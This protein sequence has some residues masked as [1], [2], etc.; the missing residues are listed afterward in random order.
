MNS[1]SY[2]FGL[3]FQISDDYLDVEKDK[4]DKVFLN[5][6]LNLG[7]KRTLEIYDFHFKKCINLLKNNLYS[8]HF[9]EILILL[10][11]RIYEQKSI[12]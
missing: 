6:F 8:K 11:K 10:N 7:K 2:S 4:S 12:Y 9:K 3:I 1:I 5:F